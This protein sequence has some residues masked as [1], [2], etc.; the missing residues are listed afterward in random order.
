MKPSPLRG[1]LSWASLMAGNSAWPGIVGILNG[2]VTGLQV[3]VSLGHGT[4]TV[5]FINERTEERNIYSHAI[6]SNRTSMT[7]M[8]PFLPVYSWSPCNL[9]DLHI[10]DIQPTFPSYCICPWYLCYL[11]CLHVR[12]FC[13]FKEGNCTL[14]VSIWEDIFQSFS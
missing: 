2:C 3:K 8:L 9:P 14:T 11:F 1:Q 13:I 10:H 7:P 4:D 5:P 6:L 12:V